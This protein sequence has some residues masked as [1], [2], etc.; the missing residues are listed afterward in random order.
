MS[1]EEDSSPDWALAPTNNVPALGIKRLKQIETMFVSRRLQG[2]RANT[3]S[4]ETLLDVLLVLYDECC[5]SS[6]RREKAVADFISYVKPVA[7]ALK[8]L[9]LSRD[10]F[11]LVKVIGRGAF[12]EVCVVRASFIQ[13]GEG[14]GT[15]PS[16][17]TS[18]RVYAMKILNKW[19]MLK[20]AD[21]ACFQ[22]ERDVLVFGDRR[23]ITNLHYA[24]Q[25]DHNLYLVMDY[26][27]GGDLLTLLSKFEDRLPEDMARFY[28]TEMVLAVQS[29]HELRYVHRD[30]K[31]DNV[32][33]D[34][35]GHI[36]LADFGSCL[37]LGDDGKVQSNVAVGTPDYISPE[38]LR[39]MEDGQGRYGPECDWWS[40]GVCMYEMLFGET[41]FYAESLVETYGKIMNHARCFHCPPPDEHA[42]QVSEEAK[43]LI[44]RLICASETRLGKNGIQDFKTHPWF[45]GVEWDAIREA[46]APFVPDV[47]S[48]TDTSNFD[49]DDTDIRLSEAV[50]PPSA[51]SA[52]SGLHLPFIGFTFTAGS[53]LSD[54]GAPTP[55]SPAKNAPS[56]A[57]SNAGERAALKALEREN[58]LLAH[59]IAELRA[60]LGE[61]EDMTQLRE[62][63]Q[64]VKKRNSELETQAKRF[65]QITSNNTAQDASSLS[66][67]ELVSKL[68]E[69]ELVIETLTAEKEELLKDKI[70]SV[71]KLRLQDKELADAVTQRKL[72]MTEY[73][74]VADKLAELRQQK[75]KLSRQVRDK[76]EELEVAMQKIDALRQDIRRADKG[77]REMEARLETA[78][79]EATKERKLREESLRLQRVEPPSAVA[80]VAKLQADIEALEAQYAESLAQQQARYSSEVSA[81]REQLHETDALR[82]MLNRELQTSKEKLENRRLEQLTDSEDKQMLINE[83]RKLAK[84]L[85]AMAENGRRWQAERRQLEMELEE[86]RAKRDT[87][88]HWETQIADIIRWVADEKEARGYLQALA[89]KMTEELDYLKHATASRT[90]APASPGAGPGVGPP[91]LGPGGGPL[92]PGGGPPG[93]GGWRNRR[94]QK[95]DKMEIL[96]LQSSLHSEIQAKQ[97]VGE[98]LSRTRAELLASQRELLETRQRLDTLA[99][100]MKRKE[101]HIRDMQA[102]LDQPQHGHNSSRQGSTKSTYWSGKEENVLDRPPSQM[103]YLE[104]FLKDAPAERHYDNVSTINSEQKMSPQ[105]RYRNVQH[106]CNSKRMYGSQ[107]STALS[108]SAESQDEMEQRAASPISC[109]SSPS[110]M[111]TYSLQDTSTAPPVAG[112]QKLHQFLVR[113]FS[114]PTKC[115]HCTSLMVS[116]SNIKFIRD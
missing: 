81:L 38:I 73:S 69:L 32:L 101:Q 41:P 58:A 17:A 114:S 90:S 43:D 116:V 67:Q 23:W 12:G 61:G 100:D 65:E 35:S 80:D 78:V 55:L 89:T 115:N 34:A 87:M 49:V 45:S 39:A 62:E 112:K 57:P 96:T 46:S 37:R 76:E 64:T 75:H 47:A 48:P 24:F 26:Y 104:Q 14:N 27:C 3:L 11:E 44:R 86:L 74:E 99:H 52:F 98:E 22:E 5:N 106:C 71:E 68:R 72:A 59:T 103:S 102:K 36:R 29:V 20:R 40:L 2:P 51:S 1:D 9:R 7:T 21:T 110:E 70:D 84:D 18:E 13:N 15:A 97:A 92:G 42:A 107:Q 95:V 54:L 8:R 25:D 19:E 88:Q 79:A 83:N 6:L 28:I 105:Y 60:G 77:R 10:D 111:S 93:P 31:P 16:A 30:I 50:P 109:K 53:R 113:T 66:P 85:D 4:V 33:L 63:L 56:Q 91:A 108:G 94:S 82:S